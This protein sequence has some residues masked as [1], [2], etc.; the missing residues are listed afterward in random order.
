MATGEAADTVGGGTAD[1]IPAHK[2]LLWTVGCSPGE[3]AW[4]AADTVSDAG[5]DGRGFTVAGEE[6][7][8]D[9]AEGTPSEDAPVSGASVCVGERPETVDGTRV[10][11]VREQAVSDGA[12]A[13]S[14]EGASTRRAR[15]SGTS[16]DSRE[17]SEMSPCS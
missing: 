2:Q 17:R 13:T 5:A 14:S 7:A 10:I 9:G 16:L 3:T 12:E 11:A 1:A 15:F 6:A 4:Q 8:S